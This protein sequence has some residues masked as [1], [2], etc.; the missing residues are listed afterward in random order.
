MREIYD[1]IKDVKEPIKSALIIVAEKLVELD[2]LRSRV[3]SLESRMDE[4]V[5]KDM[6]VKEPGGLSLG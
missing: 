2:D 4:K 6:K 5:E 1:L 3:D